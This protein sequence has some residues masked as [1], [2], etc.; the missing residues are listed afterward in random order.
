MERDFHKLKTAVNNQLK[1][2]EEKYGDLFVANV[3]NQKL[4]ELYLDSFP[5]GENPIFRERRTYDCNCC[6]H[7][8]RN[9]GNV[10]ALDGNNEYV[11]IWDI[12]TGDEV[13]DKVASVLASEV[14]KHRISRIFK[15]E[16]ETFGAEDNFDN[17]MENVRW[18]HFMYRV[19]ERYMVEKGEKNSFIGNMATRRRLLVEMLE[20]IR[21]ELFHRKHCN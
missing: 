14:R 11:T 6:K 10:V 2:M 18:T 19:S 21:N 20:N 8:F 12:E 3:D 13:F 5:E 9:I 4:W 1:D 16:L 7:F 17:Y 15:S